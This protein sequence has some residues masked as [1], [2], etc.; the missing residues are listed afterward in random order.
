MKNPLN[1]SND[2]CTTPEELKKNPRALP[3]LRE[4]ATARKNAQE[5]A[6]IFTAMWSFW[7]FEHAMDDLLDES[8]WPAE[9]K[10]LAVKALHDFV[11]AL[12]T[13][14]VYREHAGDFRALFSSAIARNIAG[15]HFAA[16]PKALL[17]A[18]A[19]AVRC[20]DIDIF[21]YFA[22]LAGGFD[23]MQKMSGTDKL[24]RYDL[25]EFRAEVPPTNQGDTK[26]S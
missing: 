7:C 5:Q 23:F 11:S 15:D 18:Q 19:P 24:R 22:E 21:T 8:G 10:L 1:P 4:I 16:S 6:D 12:L 20:A 17:Q 14:P 9:K 2:Y 3:L 26:G 25:P 13:N